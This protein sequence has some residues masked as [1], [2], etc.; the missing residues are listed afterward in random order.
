MGPASVLT[1]QRH[2]LTAL[3]QPGCIAIYVSQH[4]WQLAAMITAPAALCGTLL[5]TTLLGTC[6]ACKAAV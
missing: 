2:W 1:L 6:C 3:A 4:G 5:G